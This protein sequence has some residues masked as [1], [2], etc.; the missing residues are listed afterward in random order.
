MNLKEKLFPA[1]NPAI[2][3]VY[4]RF[5]QELADK[6]D[7][8]FTDAFAQESKPDGLA[9]LI[10]STGGETRVLT[11]FINAILKLNIPCMGFVENNAQSC[12]AELLLS[13]QYRVATPFSKICFHH[14]D[15][16]IDIVKILDPEVLATFVKNRK[17]EE[18]TYLK[19]FCEKTGQTME[20]ARIIYRADDIIPSARAIELGII[21]EVTEDLYPPHPDDFKKDN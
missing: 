9:F 13:C 14:G 19:R 8:Q 6:V 21:H 3:R 17:A 12:G 5:N 10:N 7:K 20:N 16:K 18:D 11:T 15:V 4:G 1:K 2:I